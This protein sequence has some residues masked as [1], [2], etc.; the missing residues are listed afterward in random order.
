MQFSDPS[1]GW[2][3]QFAI[4]LGCLIWA[5]RAWVLPPVRETQSEK[6]AFVITILALPGSNLRDG[7]DQG[8]VPFPWRTKPATRLKFRGNYGGKMRAVGVERQAGPTPFG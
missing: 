6:I 8:V 2:L 5:R 7:S 1:S 4:G 3:R